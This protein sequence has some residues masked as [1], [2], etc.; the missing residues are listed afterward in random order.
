MTLRLQ[1][2]LTDAQMAAAAISEFLEGVTQEDFMSNPIL[3]AAVER[4]FEILGEALN[5]ASI[6]KEGLELD[7]PDLPKIIE[8][9]NRIIHGYDSIDH[10]MLW[11]IAQTRVPLLHHHLTE[12]L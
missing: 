3:L 5:F 1:K 12:L 9:R 10:K 8:L 11:T 6:E 7:I 2:Y 4:K